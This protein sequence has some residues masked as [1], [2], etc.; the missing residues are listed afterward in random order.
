MRHRYRRRI[1]RRCGL[2][3]N[4]ALR[5]LWAGE[6]RATPVGLCLAAAM[7]AINVFINF[8]A[9]D[10]V[11]HASEGRR[12]SLM[13]AQVTA[14]RARLLSSLVVQATMTGAAVAKDPLVVAWL[15]AL[16]SLVV[17]VIMVRAGFRLLL[18]SAVPDLLDRSTGSLV[19]PALQQAM[20]KLPPQITVDSFRSRGTSR[21]LHLEVALACAENTDVAAIRRV[22]GICRPARWRRPCRAPRSISR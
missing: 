1:D 14:R 3:R 7:G 19:G 15:D 21:A 8:V 6:S 20:A 11:R 16:G 17:C 18:R 10:K 13:D 12:S 9:W 22:G 5:L 2:D 4:D